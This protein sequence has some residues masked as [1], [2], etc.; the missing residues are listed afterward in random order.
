MD[1]FGA[2]RN[3]VVKRVDE[4]HLANR[5]MGDSM[6]RNEKESEARSENSKSDIECFL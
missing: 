4:I 5:I 6:V 1:G 3:K 2:R